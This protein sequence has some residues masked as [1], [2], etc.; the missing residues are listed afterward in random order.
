MPGRICERDA[1]CNA[2][3]IL[4]TAE[5]MGARH[6]LPL[7]I[8]DMFASQSFTRVSHIA[9]VLA[10]AAA[11]PFAASAGSLGVYLSA[12]GVQSTYVQGA[13]TETFDSLPTGIQTTPFDS[14][15]GTYQFSST[16][17]FAVVNADSYGG[18][19][20][21]KYVSI[22]AQSGSSAP[23]TLDLKTPANY[24]GFWWSAGDVNN[25]LTFYYNN[26]LITRLTTADIVDILGGTSG[27]VTAINGVT[28]NSSQY[29]GNPN[30]SRD[31]SEPF[32]YV[33]VIATNT[34]FNKIVFDNSGQTGSGFE[35]DN[36]S[37]ALG[38]IKPQTT[39]VFVESVPTIDLTV[40]PEPAPMA[41]FGFGF[42]AFGLRAR[43]KKKA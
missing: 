13:T 16:D 8:P 32:A 29:Y 23:V 43:W 38:N 5:T 30:N 14:A 22:G 40:S 18:A 19:N 2:L 7:R 41:L 27:H 17:K 1:S 35:S 12:P 25:G 39:S 36:H 42:L 33:N 3:G 37:V 24:F 20:G 10:V 26:T 15:I 31:A 21:S 4:R 34:G 9:Q 11:L 28:Y 6:A